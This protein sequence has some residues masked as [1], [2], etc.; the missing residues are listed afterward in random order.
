M[1]RDWEAKEREMGAF[2]RR[3]SIEKERDSG[4]HDVDVQKVDA[5]RDMQRRAKSV[6]T[7]ITP[8][9]NRT[10]VSSVAGRYSTTRPT[11]LW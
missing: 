3:H 5:S 4:T 2:T 6:A 10:R 9:G 8:S 7:P 11:A 1:R